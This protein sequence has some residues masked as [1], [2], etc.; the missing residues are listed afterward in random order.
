MSDTTHHRGQS[1]NGHFPD[2]SPSW[3]RRLGNRLSRMRARHRLRTGRPEAIAPEK[4]D[5][6]GW[7]W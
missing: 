2:G 4:R 5:R 1:K 6:R 3:W 7:Y